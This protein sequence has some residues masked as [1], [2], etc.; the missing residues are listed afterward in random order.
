MFSK[1]S[2]YSVKGNQPLIIGLIHMYPGVRISH[3][4]KLQSHFSLIIF[5]TKYWGEIFWDRPSKWLKDMQDDTWWSPCSGEV[6]IWK[7][8]MKKNFQ[9]SLGFI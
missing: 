8:E 6:T 9:Y 1:T 7:N 3:L 2:K 4:I 5:I